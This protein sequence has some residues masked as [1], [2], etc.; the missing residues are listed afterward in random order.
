VSIGYRITSVIYGNGNENGKITKNGYETGKN[1]EKQNWNWKIFHNLNHTDRDSVS[2]INVMHMSLL[3][4]R[5]CGMPVGHNYHRGQ[6][7]PL[8]TKAN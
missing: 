7:R 1:S 6:S 2:Y 5:N 3:Q 8:V 4:Q